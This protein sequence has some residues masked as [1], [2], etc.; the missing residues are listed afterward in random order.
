[1]VRFSPCRGL[2]A[3]RFS[4]PVIINRHKSSI[5]HREVRKFEFFVYSLLREKNVRLCGHFNAILKTPRPLHEEDLTSEVRHSVILVNN[6]HIAKLS[7]M[8]IT[9][10]ERH[11]F[12]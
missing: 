12:F 2:S 8:V 6:Q 1:V 9:L 10:L 7:K 5:F 3:N 11:D 4:Q